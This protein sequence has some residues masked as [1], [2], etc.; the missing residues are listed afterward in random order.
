MCDD[1]HGEPVNTGCG[2]IMC[3]AA[4]AERLSV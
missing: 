4:N 3:D 1:K 2:V